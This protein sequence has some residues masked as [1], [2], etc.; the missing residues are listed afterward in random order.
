M[1]LTLNTAQLTTVQQLTNN[2]PFTSFNHLRHPVSASS[3]STLE[4]PKS[5]QSDQF[6]IFVRHFFL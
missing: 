5:G 6:I 2:P 3:T 1:Q 4:S